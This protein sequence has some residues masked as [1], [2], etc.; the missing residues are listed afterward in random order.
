MKTCPTWGLALPHWNLRKMSG[1]STHHQAN[2][3][4]GVGLSARSAATSPVIAALRS[5]SKE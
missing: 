1:T 3:K 4:L 2:H 5:R